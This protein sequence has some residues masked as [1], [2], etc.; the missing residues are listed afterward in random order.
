[1]NRLTINFNTPQTCTVRVGAT[2]GPV[3]NYAESFVNGQHYFGLTG[4]SVS[5]V[6]SCSVAAGTG[7]AQGIAV[8]SAIVSFNM[9]KI[10]GD[11]EE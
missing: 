6:G 5:L 8:G 1:M 11:A 9:T 2:Q 7:S 3:C 10:A 4:G